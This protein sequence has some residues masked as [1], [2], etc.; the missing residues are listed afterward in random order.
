MSGDVVG[1]LLGFGVRA[2]E[3]DFAAGD[4]VLQAVGAIAAA[5]NPATSTR[6]E[7]TRPP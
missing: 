3:E 7:I 1:V 4:V 2:A 5:D 6:L